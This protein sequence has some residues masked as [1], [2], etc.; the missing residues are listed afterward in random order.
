DENARRVDRHEAALAPRLVVQ[1]IGD[2]R[3][4]PAERGLRLRGVVDLDRHDHAAAVENVRS[5]R[6]GR[7]IRAHETETDLAARVRAEHDDPRFLLFWI[8]LATGGRCG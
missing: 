5:G 3:A 1:V 8:M 6:A 2:R 7:M 4:L